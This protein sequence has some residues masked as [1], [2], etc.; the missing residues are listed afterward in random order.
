VG[1]GGGG[2]GGAHIKGGH[3]ENSISTL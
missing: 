1:C 3:S 2:G